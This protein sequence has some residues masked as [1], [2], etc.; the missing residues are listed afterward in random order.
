MQIAQVNGTA[1]CE[2]LPCVFVGAGFIP[3]RGVLGG[4]KP[5]GDK[6][7]PYTSIDKWILFSQLG[8]SA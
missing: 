8:L 1:L 2:A 7:R 4:K 3:A 5:G 6:P